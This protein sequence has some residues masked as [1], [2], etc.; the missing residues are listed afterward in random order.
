M[1]TPL[2]VP[3]EEIDA[4]EEQEET[5]PSKTYKFDINTGEMSA[6]FIDGDEAI[7]QAVVKYVKTVRDKYL[8][9]STDYGCEITYLLGEVYTMEYLESEVP[10]FI[11]ECLS[12]DDRIQGTDEYIIQL[13]E[14]GN[15]LY[16]SFNVI[17]DSGET[18][19]IEVEV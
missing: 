16:I 8:I 4:V 15:Q 18:I 10:R 3:I 7:R 19:E 14:N 2:I 13:L 12:V 17:T 6:Q 11:D 1:I 9:Y 5:L